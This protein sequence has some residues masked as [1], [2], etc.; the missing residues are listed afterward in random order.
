[1]ELE[2]IIDSNGAHRKKKRVGSGEGNGHGK[3]CCRGQKGSKA[4][5]GYSIRP[6]F[7]GG[8]MPL[9]LKSPRRGFS[10]YRHAVDFVVLNVGDLAKFE[11]SKTINL[12]FLVGVGFA[13]K[14][15]RNLKLLANGEV[16]A[17]YTLE[18]SK[19]SPA[20]IAK[21]EQAGG[22]VVIKSGSAES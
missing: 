6:G 7:E 2:S 17:P 16:S 1:M 10:N 19:A 12:D 5:S 21:I 13:K 9:Y 11:S 22:K 3:T 4:R 8:Q 20:A 18:V 15:S 14:D